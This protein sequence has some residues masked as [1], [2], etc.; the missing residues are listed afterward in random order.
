MEIQE[1]TLQ[2]MEQVNGGGLLGGGLLGGLLGCNSGCNDSCGGID[3][4]VKLSIG[5]CL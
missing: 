3:I 1:L 4:K 2:E 5:I